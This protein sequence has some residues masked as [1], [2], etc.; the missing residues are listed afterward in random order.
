MDDFV[1]SNAAAGDSLGDVGGRDDEPDDDHSTSTRAHTDYRPPIVSNH[2]GWA[3]GCRHTA[4][5]TVTRR[6]ASEWPNPGRKSWTTFVRTSHGR[7]S[8]DCNDHYCASHRSWPTVAFAAG[9]AEL[10]PCACS[11]KLDQHRCFVL[12]VEPWSSMSPMS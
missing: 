3:A 12:R 1:R 2:D 11:R 5:I 9:A 8:L 10:S 4:R 7:T 6:Y